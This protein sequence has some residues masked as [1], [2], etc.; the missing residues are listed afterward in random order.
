MYWIISEQLIVYLCVT[1]LSVWAAG[2]AVEKLHN[3]IRENPGERKNLQKKQ[4][5]IIAGAVILNTGILAVL[6]YSGFAVMN[7]TEFMRIFGVELTVKPP[8]Y[9]LP[10][11]I[12][13]YTLQAISYIVD[14]YRKVNPAEKN[15]FRLGLFIGFF[16]LIIEGPISRYSQLKDQLFRGQAV[17][18][19]GLKYGMIRIGYGLMKKLVIADR[20]NILIKDVFTNYSSYDGG[21]ILF[22]V[23]AYTC[24]L[25]MEFSGTMDVVVGTGEIFNIRIA[26][27]FQR[28]FFS[29]SISEFWMRW[30][31]SLGSWFKDYVFYPVS[32]SAPVKNIRK[33][34]KNRM[35]PHSVALVTSSVALFSVWILNGIW[36]GSGWNYIFFGMY[37]FV[38]IFMANLTEPYLL[39]V[40]DRAGIDR[41]KPWYVAM[42]IIKTTV[43]VCFGELFFRAP[44]LQTGMEMFRK[45]FTDFSLKGFL[46]ASGG[47]YGLDYKDLFIVLVTTGIV[48]TVSL[49]NEKN[50]SLRETLERRNIAVRWGF[51]YAMG[52]FIIIFGAYGMGYI[53]VDPIYANF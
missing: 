51:Y 53:P 24:Q 45:I 25:Y 37:H 39:K 2:M 15:I 41:K 52:M 9:L 43:I 10:I 8:A 11:G 12:S 18:M 47:G 20:L 26:E 4:R 19:T 34:L 6:K 3:R 38:F 33:K 49:L 46:T 27:N 35:S 13:F 23:F 50:I 28:P 30:H 40:L 14:V 29:K 1:V 22:A 32:L 48:F 21:V 5:R 7:L 31:I 42:R 36:H 17:N 16:P 44:D